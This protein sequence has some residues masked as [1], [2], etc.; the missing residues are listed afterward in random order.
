MQNLK[1][2]PRLFT[3][4]RYAPAPAPSESGEWL[5]S[6]PETARC[7]LCNACVLGGVCEQGHTPHQQADGTA[8]WS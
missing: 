8:V 2:R 1:T 3:P 6:A 5:V 7:A 4:P